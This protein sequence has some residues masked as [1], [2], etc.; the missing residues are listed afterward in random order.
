MFKTKIILAL[1]GGFQLMLA[2][3]LHADVITFD[4]G[5]QI[6][7]TVKQFWDDEISIE[8]DYADEFKVLYRWYG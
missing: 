6:T 7:G 8:P 3:P 1:M 5:D 2:A 4:N